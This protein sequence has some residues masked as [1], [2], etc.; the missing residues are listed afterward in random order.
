MVLEGAS[1]AGMPEAASS[2]SGV[3]L[4]KLQWRPQEQWR[5]AGADLNLEGLSGKVPLAGLFSGSLPL[6]F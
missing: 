3:P 5:K 4:P 1:A 2:V 6:C